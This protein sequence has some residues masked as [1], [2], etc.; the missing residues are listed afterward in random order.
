MEDK[1]KTIQK[2]AKNNKVLRIQ[3]TDRKDDDS[4]RNVEPY[5]IRGDHLFAYC[6][7]RKGIRRFD[8][9]KMNSV[10]ETQYTYMPKYPV[11]INEEMKKTASTKYDYMIGNQCFGDYE[12]AM[13][14]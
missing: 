6:R 5:E 7:K 11:K 1:L 8:M 4:I 3:Y 10:K 14:E 2:A 13:V 9:N 12:S